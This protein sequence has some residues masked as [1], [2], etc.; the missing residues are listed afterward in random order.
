MPPMAA[1]IGR[2]A[3]LK[4]ESS[5]C[6]NSLLISRV[7]KKKNIAIKT[8]FIQCNTDNLRPKLLMP[9]KKYFSNVSKYKYDNDELLIIRAKIA[10][11]NNI[12]PLAASSLKNHL[13]GE[14]KYF[15]IVYFIKSNM[16]NFI[17]S[18]D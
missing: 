8:S 13:N 5:P 16:N 2:S 3:C 12:N 9:R 17:S 14:D 15:I 18:R 1:I 4:L 11:I 10:L 6:I 7:T